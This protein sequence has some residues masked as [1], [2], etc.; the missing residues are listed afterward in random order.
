MMGPYGEVFA[1]ADA[2]DSRT[3]MRRQFSEICALSWSPN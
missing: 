1:S 3:K 2:G